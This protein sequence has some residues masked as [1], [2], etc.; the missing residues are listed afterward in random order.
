MKP[1][2]RGLYVLT[3]P[4]FGT[5]LSARVKDALA[6]G[7]S[8]IQFRDKTSA[9]GDKRRM[10][11]TLAQLCREQKVPFIVNDNPALALAV[12]ADGVHLGRDDGS[13]AEARRRLGGQ[14]LIG[15]SCYADPAIAQRACAH[16][17]DY[18]AFGSFYPSRTKPGASPAPLAVLSQA[19]QQLAVPICAIGGIDDYNAPPLIAAG[20][21]LIAVMSAV[22]S[23][24]DVAKAAARLSKLFVSE[25]SS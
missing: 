7:A 25:P 13:I 14:L 19:R 9:P 15:A 24:P 23:A 2:L 1:S 3:D 12:G 20:A 18:V 17:A 11:E 6:G 10:A 21:D 4:C 16:G 8:L 22:L 5:D